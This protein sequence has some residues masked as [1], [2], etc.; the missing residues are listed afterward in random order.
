VGIFLKCIQAVKDNTPEGFAAIKLT[1]LGNPLLLE[2]LT[3]TLKEI[4]NFFQEFDKTG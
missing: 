1:A 4:R 2:R 3:V